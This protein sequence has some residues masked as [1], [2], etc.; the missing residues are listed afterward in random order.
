MDREKWTLVGRGGGNTCGVFSIIKVP[1][2]PAEPETPEKHFEDRASVGSSSCL[3]GSPF[4]SG[5]TI[6]KTGKE[7]AREVYSQGIYNT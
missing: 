4:Q 6:E 7:K 1:Q 5:V 3:S 2:T